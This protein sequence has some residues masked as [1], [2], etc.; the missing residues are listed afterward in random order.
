MA[1][2]LRGDREGAT[3]WASSATPR[4]SPTPWSS[5]PATGR[6]AHQRRQPH[7][8]RRLPEA[9]RLT[10]DATPARTT[11][12]MGDGR[13]RARRRRRSTTTSTSPGASCSALLAE[14]D[15][16]RVRVPARLRGHTWLE[17]GQHAPILVS[18]TCDVRPSE[19]RAA[20]RSATGSRPAA[21]WVALHGTNAALDQRRQ[22]L[23]ERR[24]TSRCGSTRSAAQFIAHPPIRRTPS[25]NVAPDHWLVAGVEPF[26]TD[27]RAVPHRVPRPRA[28]HAAA[29]HHVA[30]RGHAASPRATGTAG[31]RRPPGDVPAAARRRRGAVQH[32]RALP[33]PLRHGARSRT[34]T[35][36]IDR[37][38]W[39]LP[40]FYE[41]LRRSLRWAR[42]D[43]E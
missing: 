27:R 19:R 40:V 8:R 20:G 28:L 29:A 32:A 42:G 18:Y 22:G 4:T 12:P 17:L 34:T 35:R 33:R 38:S 31:D 41:L 7:G 5:S 10:D 36:T 1:R 23:V 24:A 25:S 39:D 6:Q 21:A 11:R 9:R 3:R 2:V 13:R 15:E 30:G 37:C 43:D 26:E 14:H 16:F